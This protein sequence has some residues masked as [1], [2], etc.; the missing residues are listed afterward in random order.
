MK[1]LRSLLAFGMIGCASTKSKTAP[2][3]AATASPA[4]AATAPRSLYERLGGR[5]AIGAVVDEFLQRVAADKRINARFFNTDLVRLRGLLVDFLC[6][7]AGGSGKYEGRDMHSAHAGLN[8]VSEEFDALVEDLVGALKKLN[9]PAA[10]QNDVLGA[11]GPL[12]PQIVNPPSAEAAKH[13]PKL[14]D[15]GNALVAALRKAGKTQP[16]DLLEVALVARTRGQRNYAEQLFS[17]VERDVPSKELAALNP[18]FRAG[19]PE[20]ITTPLKTM[21]KDTPPQPKGAVG[22][23]DD[24]E[25]EAKQKP[26]TTASLAG[27]VRLDDKPLTDHLAVLMLTPVS[28][29][30][31]R[32][33]PKHRV[34]EQRDRMFAP[35]IMAV[36]LGSTVAFP[37]FDPVFHN[38]FSV[39]STRAFDLGIYKNGESREVKFDKEGFVRLGC[40]LHANMAAYLVVVAAPHYVITNG[41]GA[42]KFSRLEP[43]KYRLKAWVESLAEPIVETVEVKPGANSFT[44]EARGAAVADLGT[45]KFGAPRGQAQ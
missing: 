39:S 9:V 31:A 25:P 22:S 29:K 24:D 10:E 3:A 28:G 6:A 34:I 43:G 12:K 38:V 21:P 16:S 26:K 23:S 14:V 8:L 15:K 33:S 17:A 4:P 1:L 2:P 30:Y 32:R 13:D 44:V 36:P 35:H 41:K 19:A 27:L 45:D 18:L 37:N 42:F 40:N 11:L 20:R 5:P 7:A